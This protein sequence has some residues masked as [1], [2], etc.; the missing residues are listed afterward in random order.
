MSP[1]CAP[2]AVLW[3]ALLAAGAGAQSPPSKPAPAGP[4][5]AELARQA[6]EA[7]EAGRLEDAVRLYRRGLR[8]RPK[9]DEGWWYLGTLHYE[10][11]RYAEAREAFRRFL[12]LKP[13][14]GPAWA[15]RG[16]C[17]FQEKDY[18]A[19][20]DHLLKG[21]SLGLGGNAEVLR[22]ARYRLALLYVKAGQFELS[23]EPLTL[24][25]RSEPESQGLV[26]AVGLMVLRQPLFPSE[27]P[28]AR[29]DLVRKAGRAGLLHLARRGE[30]AER[31]FAELVEAYPNEPWVHYARGI[32][33][34]KGDTDEGLAEL[35]RE[36]EVQPG[37]VFAHLEIAFE[38]LRRRDGAGARPWAEKAAALAP[39]LFAARNALGRA[40]V[41]VGEL[42]P[43]IRELEEAVRLAPDSPEMHF[44]LGLAYARAGRT[45]EAARAR[46]SFL[47]LDRKRREQRGE[48]PQGRDT[49]GG[50]E[51][52]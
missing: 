50:A 8:L 44:S 43:G 36:L 27:V 39:D 16:L 5:F 23:V 25:A 38:L 19:S 10:A 41:E 17:D 45:E 22:V 7:R 52:P 20:L 13:D 28:E 2:G 15:L 14:V 49:A 47:E 35:R 4:P 24:L 33:L 37:N 31:A 9:W 11:D 34:L 21:L 30:E 51:R 18:P 29:R 3:F 32:F 42:E 26:E 6:S 1:F 46:A 40:L 48:P 12:A